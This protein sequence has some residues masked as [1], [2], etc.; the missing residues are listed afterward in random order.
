MKIS[1]ENY[2]KNNTSLHEKSRPNFKGV[3]ADEKINVLGRDVF[4]AV[5][6]VLL[7]KGKNELFSNIYRL[8]KNADILIQPVVSTKIN[9]ETFERE[10]T[11]DLKN[12]YTAIRKNSSYVEATFSLE[13]NVIKNPVE[14]AKK[15]ET[16]IFNLFRKIENP[17]EPAEFNDNVFTFADKNI[18]EG[19][20]LALTPAKNNLLSKIQELSQKAEIAIQPINL[21]KEI[22]TDFIYVGIRKKNSQNTYTDKVYI[23]GYDAPEEFAKSIERHVIDTFDRAG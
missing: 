21:G 7:P 19:I 11:I 16:H 22:D 14:F 10:N 20:K 23:K 12:L 5:R 2:T 4:D 3:W 9:P 18:F 17:F 8:S 1:L 15:L 13:E 6:Y